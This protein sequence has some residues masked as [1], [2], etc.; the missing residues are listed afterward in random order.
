MCFETRMLPIMAISKSD[1]DQK[2]KNLETSRKI[3][4]QEM[5]QNESSLLYD[6][7]Y[8]FLQKGQMFKYSYKH[9]I[10]RNIHVMLNIISMV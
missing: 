5:M 7:R 9:L 4:S 10:E 1:Q 2:D 8:F 3:L 6:Q